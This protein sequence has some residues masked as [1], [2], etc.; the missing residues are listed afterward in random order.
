MGGLHLLIALT[1]LLTFSSVARAQDCF[2]E[3]RDLFGKAGL[4]KTREYACRTSDNDKAE[5]R[6][7]HVRLDEPLAAAVVLNQ[8]WP[9]FKALFGTFTTLPNDVTDELKVLFSQ[10]GRSSNFYLSRLQLG[11]QSQINST[12]TISESYELPGSRNTDETIQLWSI[13]APIDYLNGYAVP[14]AIPMTNARKSILLKSQWPKGFKHLYVCQSNAVLCTSPWTYMEFKQIGAI[15]RD[16]AAQ[17]K[18]R[19]KAEGESATPEPNSSDEK[20]WFGPEVRFDLLRHLGQAG[21]PQSFI[22]ISGDAGEGCGGLFEFHY[23]MPFMS[24]DFAI[25]ENTSSQAIKIDHLTGSEAGASKSLRKR[26]VAKGATQKIKGDNIEIASGSKVVVPLRIVFSNDTK[27]GTASRLAVAN[28]MYKRIS[29]QPAGA[30][31]TQRFTRVWEPGLP[32][33]MKMT[34]PKEAFLSPELPERSEFVFGREYQLDGLVMRNRELVLKAPPLH[35][36]AVTRQ[37]SRQEIRH[38]EEEPTTKLRLHQNLSMEGSCPILYTLNPNAT[39]WI[40]HGK[41]IHEANSASREGSTTIDV[42][43]AARVF[44]LVEEE[45]EVA[46][47]RSVKLHITLKDGRSVLLDPVGIQKANDDFQFIIEERQM[48][49]FSFALS[50]HDEMIGASSSK[51]IVTGYYERYAASLGYV[52]WK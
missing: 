17:E 32:K 15:E 19:R 16:I 49:T 27:W 9:E 7:T 14:C 3:A 46:Y 10:F 30:I 45:P 23:Y 51:L 43:P 47:I 37:F 39:R 1:V 12:E 8:Q 50:P 4:P 20:E 26:S 44:R 52:H 24:V 2:V 31:F 25:I 29:S 40:R 13:T 33:N 42:D 38:E 11:V 35:Q 22:V 18:A 48:A 41:V 36:L 28:K 21:L 5:L 34:M 6:V